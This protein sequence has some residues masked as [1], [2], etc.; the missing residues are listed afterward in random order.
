MVLSAA[1]AEAVPVTEA[2]AEAVPVTEAPAGVAARAGTVGRAAAVVRA[3]ASADRGAQGDRAE[4]AVGPGVPGTGVRLLQDR[5]RVAA[6]AW[7]SAAHRRLHPASPARVRSESSQP[8]WPDL[9]RRRTPRYLPRSAAAGGQLRTPRRWPR[10]APFRLAGRPAPP[11][12]GREHRKGH[13]RPNR[14]GCGAR[15]GHRHPG[16][17]GLC[18][19]RFRRIG[20]AAAS[21][22]AGRA[23]VASG[24]RPWLGGVAVAAPARRPPTPAEC[25]PRLRPD[26]ARGAAG[27]GDVEGCAPRSG[28]GDW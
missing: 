10:A 5:S 6:A 1:R 20:A 3:M 14:I 28:L 11:R 19:T 15:S 24:S 22:C 9:P 23:G 26:S 8:R 7:R 4:A 2:R 25:P 12:H 16:T 27:G 21:S 17:R 13:G 18:P